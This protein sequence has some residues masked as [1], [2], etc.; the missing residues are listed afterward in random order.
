MK[1]YV[2]TLKELSSSVNYLNE[3]I[4]IFESPD[5]MESKC[6]EFLGQYYTIKNPKIEKEGKHINVHYKRYGHELVSRFVVSE[7][8]VGTLVKY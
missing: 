6:A 8:V 7:F 2:L 5:D 1:L 4:G 3:V